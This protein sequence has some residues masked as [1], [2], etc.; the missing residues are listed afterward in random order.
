MVKSRKYEFED[1]TVI[2]FSSDKNTINLGIKCW[3]ETS[4]KITNV[5]VVFVGIRD[6]QVDGIAASTIEMVSED[7][8]IIHFEVD[9][10]RILLIVIWNDQAKK[11]Q[12]TKSY[13]LSF[14][15]MRI[16]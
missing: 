12:I 9:N 11:T 4:H 16:A 5:S 6:I 2:G 8:E 15:L 3:D 13:K 1:Q 10:H 14:E 7:G